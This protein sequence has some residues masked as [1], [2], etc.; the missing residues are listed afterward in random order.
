MKIKRYILFAVVLIVTFMSAVSST[1]GA[2]PGNDRDISITFFDTSPGTVTKN[3]EFTVTAYIQNRSGQ[4]MQDV[5]VIIEENASFFLPKAGG[6]VMIGLLN[7][8]QTIPVTFPNP[9]KYRGTGSILNFRIEYNIGG[10]QYEL[11][12]SVTVNTE[13]YT[14]PPVTPVDPNSLVPQISV[15]ADIPMPTLKAG[16]S[17]SLVLPMQNISNHAA[18]DVSISIDFSDLTTYIIPDS[19]KLVQQINNI[20]AKSEVT[21]EFPLKL[22]LD[23]PERV[24]PITIRYSCEN[25]H[26]KS[27]QYSETIYIKV[28]N[29]YSPPELLVSAISTKP[30]ELVPGK[31]V[32]VSLT[33]YNPGTSTAK[34][35]K[36]QV[37]KLSNDTIQAYGAGDIKYIG[38]ILGNGQKVLSFKLKVSEKLSGT[39]CPIG[40][41]FEYE[42]E[43]GK[44]YSSEYETYL[45]VEDRGEEEDALLNFKDI[46]LSAASVIPGDTFDV[47][48]KIANTGEGKAGNI[49]VWI[50]G[51]QGMITKSLTPLRVKSLDAGSETELTFTMLSD[52]TLTGRKPM[53]IKAQYQSGSG[54]GSIHTITQYIEVEMAVSDEEGDTVP[55]IIVENYTFD[56]GVVKAGNNFILKMFF[57]NTNKEI[58]V[59]NIKVSLTSI[60]GTFT[61]VNTSNTFYIDEI[62]TGTTVAKEIEL[63]PKAD[64]TPKL[65]PV[66]LKMEY[67]DHRGK[68]YTATETLNIPLRQ[69]PRLQTSDFSLPPQLFVGQTTYLYTDFY[70]MGKSTLYNL[71]VRLEG[72]F[73]GE[74]NSYF[75]GNFEPGRSDYYEGMIIPQNPGELK[76]KLVFEFEDE[77]GEQ[78]RVEK[79]FTV[80]VQEMQMMF[81][82]DMP[83]MRPGMDKPGMGMEP[84]GGPRIKWWMY[85]AA[86]VALAVILLVVF[87]VIRKRGKRIAEGMGLYE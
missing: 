22:R 20:S 6:E 17:T 61:P 74:G 41:K 45:T 79:E 18:R 66:E 42:D 27:F 71:M 43:M 23:T 59:K 38:S 78:H 21:A 63:Y 1:W 72:E 8:N 4:N 14:A 75:A 68:Q 32:D 60:D 62:E 67:E 70:N 9:V 69:E 34:N 73:G 40:F 13:E 11:L 86:G 64:A 19:V 53:A 37:T 39:Y 36:V 58:P 29:D 48:F 54:Q 35:V 80:Y 12:K 10:T 33:L 77:T 31:E 24:Y 56:P 16:K 15:P 46:R 81:P 25:I 7:D 82:E 52:K 83:G 57:H 2:V 5:V 47:T 3:D 65:Y 76:G 30:D 87:L 85:T 51:G 26:G 28:E 50:E 84:G 49:E 44:K 55:R